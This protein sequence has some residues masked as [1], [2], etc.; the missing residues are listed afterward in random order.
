MQ[1][2]GDLNIEQ[3]DRI[4]RIADLRAE[5]EKLAGQPVAEWH[6]PDLPLDIQEQFWKHV[7]EFE[8]QT[9]S[10]LEDTLRARFD[11]VP[12]PLSNL[13]DDQ[14][15]NAALWSLIE[16]LAKLRVYIH[17]TNH[18]SDRELYRFLVEEVLPDE[19]FVSAPG[20][21]W[22]MRIDATYCGS[23]DDGFETFLSYYADE[24][25]R[26]D[27]ALEYPDMPIP[28]RQNPQS[29]RDARLPNPEDEPF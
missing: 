22:N 28:P 4:L 24:D 1:D 21:E 20:S 3:V 29:D 18:L 26:I 15:V 13:P 6:P 25:M 10:T 8:S 17:Y 5:V 19:T 14:S 12:T 16:I 11:F 23:H 7:L 2:D 9:V 27:T